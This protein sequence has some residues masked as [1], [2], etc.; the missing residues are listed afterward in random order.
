MLK[1]YN[2][3]NNMTSYSKVLFRKPNTCYMTNIFASTV[4]FSDNTSRIIYK[5]VASMNGN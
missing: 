2:N 1:M 3:Y 5:T 4:E